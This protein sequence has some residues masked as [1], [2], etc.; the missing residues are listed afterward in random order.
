MGLDSV[1]LVIAIEREFDLEI[2]D[3]D[4]R[5]MIT[6]GDMYDFVH[7]ALAKRA[8]DAGAPAPDQAELWNKVLDIIVEEVGADRRRLVREARFI[9]DLG[10]N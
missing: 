5:T 8:Q 3:A 6:V 2:P 1:E 7:R 10:V 9:A 4:A